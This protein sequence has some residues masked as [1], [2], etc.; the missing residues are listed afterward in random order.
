[1]IAVGIYDDLATAH[2][3]VEHDLVGAGVPRQHR[4]Q[5]LG[6]TGVTA[7]DPHVDQLTPRDWRAVGVVP[8][9]RHIGHDRRRLDL[10][11]NLGVDGRRRRA[12]RTRAACARVHLALDHDD[13]VRLEQQPRLL[14][15]AWKQDD[16]DRAGQVFERCVSH[17]LTLARHDAPD[18]AHQ[19]RDTNLSVLERARHLDR[20]R[21]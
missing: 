13:L 12:A 10:D 15:D 20:L 6:E 8:Q 17:D 16:V 21:I 9:P 7:R 14:K 4:L 5:L 18:L 1:M 2:H 11:L 3:D 19:A